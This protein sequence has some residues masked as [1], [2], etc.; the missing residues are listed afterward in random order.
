ME[1]N[2][3]VKLAVLKCDIEHV[4]MSE[5]VHSKLTLLVKTIAK[6]RSTIQMRSFHDVVFIVLLRCPCFLYSVRWATKV[7]RELG[8]FNFIPTE[9]YCKVVGEEA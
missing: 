2:H 3:L 7:L 8:I 1:R 9:K 4:L 6:S 5:G